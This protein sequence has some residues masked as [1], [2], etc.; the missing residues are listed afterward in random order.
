MTAAILA[1]AGTAVGLANA[2]AAELSL[3]AQPDAV[4][5]HAAQLLLDGKPLHARALLS[6]LT[7]PKGS[8]GLTDAQRQRVVQLMQEARR[9][10]Q[11]LSPIR[12]S[13]DRAEI[14]LQS[15]D[16]RTVF[17]QADA[18][19]RAESALDAEK[20][21]AQSLADAARARRDAF[22]PQAQAV[23]AKAIAD[24]EAARFTQA[25]AGFERVFL[26]GVTLPPESEALLDDYMIRLVEMDRAGA[27]NE[28]SAGMVQPGVIK[29]AEQPPPSGAGDQPPP[30]P[31]PDTPAAQPPSEPVP[32]P[33]LIAEAR[34]LEAQATLAEANRA[35]AE[36]RLNEALT[37]FQRLKDAFFDLLQPDQQR[38]VEERL[39]ETRIR[40][41]A[42]GP[43]INLLGE[44]IQ[45][46]TLAR[47]Q[48][49]AEFRNELNQ[50]RGKL[51][52]GDPD[53]A[54]QHIARASLI[55]NNGRNAFSETDFR[56]LQ[57][58]AE[59]L[60]IDVEAA[61]DRIRAEQRA[62][63][64][65]ELKAAAEAARRARESDRDRKIAE[66]VQRVVALMR[67]MR[68]EEARQVVDQ[69]LFLDPV[70]P[71]GLIL[72][73]SVEL[74]LATV[75][76]NRI[77]RDRFR[78]YTTQSIQNQE[79]LIAPERIMAYP[80]DWPSISYRRGQPVPFSETPANRQILGLLDQRR[81]PAEFSDHTLAQAIDYVRG[82]SGV[83]VD[84]NWRS[85]ASLGVS[86]DTR[87]S[88][89]LTN[90][91]IRTV[92]DRLSDHLSPGRDSRVGWAVIDGILVI[93][94]QHDLDRADMPAHV[95]DIRDLLV[96]APN[97]KRTVDFDLDS[98]LA[99]VRRERALGAASPFTD[100]PAESAAMTAPGTEDKARQI[101]AL[102]QQQIDPEGWADVGGDRGFIQHLNGSL[103]ITTTPR[104]HRQ[105]TG[106]LQRLREVRNLQINVEARFLLVSQD[107]MERIGF[108]I[109]VYFNAQN[110]QV[111]FARANDP[112]IQTSDF[113]DFSGQNPSGRGLT[114]Q[115]RGWGPTGG[116]LGAIAEG[117]RINQ[118]VIPP[119]RWSPI[120]AGQ[121]SSSITSTLLPT[122]GIA[123][124]LAGMAPALGVSGQFLDDV[125]VDFLIEATQADRRSVALT[126]PR[127]TFTN[128]QVA[129][130]VV[131][132]QRGFVADLTP[133]VSESAAAF[134][135]APASVSEGVRLVVEGYVT[136]DRRYVTLNVD[137]AIGQIRGFDQ[138][139]VTAVA[140][141]QLVS[142]AD[143]QSFI[144]LPT[145]T[146]TQ[147]QTTVTVPDQGTILLGGQRLMAETEVESGVPVLS[148]IPILNR[149]F[150]NR[151]MVKEEQT[152]LILLKPTVL[153]QNEEEERAFPGLLDGLGS[154]IGGN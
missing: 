69:I 47:Q 126:A 109:D 66:N 132:T 5:E 130:I 72:R 55:L 118:A 123:G 129:N 98:V 106:L 85:L 50:A 70:N 53:T 141:G 154:S 56:Q 138:I 1:V 18:V 31:T 95:Y 67:E 23:L 73:D 88:L 11:N 142:S 12:V 32:P 13:L 17:H 104:N 131:A 146:V 92:L 54:L 113:F 148:K 63:Q 20:A 41:R 14:A 10:A 121:N 101:M 33:D 80:P 25:H 97:Y 115:I 117:D 143:T 57:N 21:A 82:V 52:A 90:V 28:A 140:G 26:S 27:L 114:R 93:A 135:P 76:Q 65:E 74:T 105:I 62:R 149:F 38:Q 124:D 30:E 136:A 59:Q 39:A 112:S 16:L 119:D 79:A 147:V 36:N 127:L 44:V 7:S 4:I 35:F 40:L 125:Q 84:V 133:V 3:T 19:L 51:A 120:G 110:N 122:T 22:A 103:L 45:R 8:L 99:K 6:P 71:A 89:N 91:P 128:G 108:D 152:L 75:Q 78:S 77:M 49:L 24:F 68:Y 81:I 150:S 139:A 48:T 107:F 15:G 145:V 153:I 42:G 58:E 34:R 60:R 83:N 137:T 46:D 61:R 134:D 102:I 116:Q 29:P 96:D 100:I 151:A 43:S 87:V 64:E 144:Q 111:R 9:S 86:R 94:A 37:G 2:Q